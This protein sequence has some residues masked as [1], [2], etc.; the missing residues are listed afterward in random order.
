MSIAGKTA[1][2]TGSTSG[3]GLGIAEALAQAG[4]QAREIVYAAPMPAAV[5]DAIRTAWRQLQAQV[6]R[7]PRLVALEVDRNA[8]AELDGL[9]QTLKERF[10]GVTLDDHRRWQQRLQRAHH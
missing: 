5:D 9:R 6:R 7:G 8:P 4:A 10:K 1:I 3:I 2:V